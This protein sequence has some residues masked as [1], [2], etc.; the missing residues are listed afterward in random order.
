MNWWVVVVL[1]L[2]LMR[3]CPRFWPLVILC[4]LAGRAV[5]NQT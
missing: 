4:Y 5:A 2:L 3:V 1:W